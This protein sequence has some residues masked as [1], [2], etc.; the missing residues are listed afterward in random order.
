V[1]TDRSRGH[2]A[3]GAGGSVHGAWPEHGIGFSY[4]LNRMSSAPDDVRAA[5]LLDALAK[6]IER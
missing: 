3:T 5:A 4:A 6:S 1:S 2:S